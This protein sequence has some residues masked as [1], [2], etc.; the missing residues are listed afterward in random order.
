MIN[1][2]KVLSVVT[3]RANSQ[4]L[5][6]KNYRNFFGRPLVQ[7]SILASL[8]CCYVDKTIVS[9]NCPYV[10]LAT[11][12]L[13][14]LTDVYQ[15]DLNCLYFLQRPEEFATPTSKNEEALIHAYMY[16]KDQLQLDAD[17]II[18][19]QPTSPIRTNELLSK[20]LEIMLI[21][22]DYDSLL[23]VTPTTPFL[24]QIDSNSQP[25]P[26]Y[27][28]VNRPMRQEIKDSDLLW[29]DN[30]NVYITK[31]ETLLSRKCRVGDHPFL[32][33]TDEFQSLQIDTEKDFILLEKI[34]ENIGG[35]C[36]CE[37]RS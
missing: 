30:G 9:S 12:E 26:M 7:W 17:I 28:V 6:G 25:R 14:K 11:E 10:K 29:H 22:E 8:D 19:L 32:F 20:C 5:P 33:E 23:T 15:M 24:W 2:N 27:D 13:I 35:P 1:G 3:A 37:T 16:A 34:T 31:K 4:G 36:S 18:N 21:K